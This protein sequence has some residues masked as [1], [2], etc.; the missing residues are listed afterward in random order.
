MGFFIG[1]VEDLPEGAKYSHKAV[2]TLPSRPSHDV[3]G[4]ERSKS[5]AATSTSQPAP[6]QDSGMLFEKSLASS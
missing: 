3:D 2:R 1:D 4:D 6:D 5:N